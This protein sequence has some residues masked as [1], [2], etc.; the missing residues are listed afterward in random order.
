M[1]HPLQSG[2]FL[3]TITYDQ[4]NGMSACCTN[5]VEDGLQCPSINVH[6][7]RHIESLLA[8]TLTFDLQNLVIVCQNSRKSDDLG[9][10]GFGV[11]EQFAVNL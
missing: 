7:F 6:A 8:M 10:L 11:T 2:F 1:C 4:V 5:L 3:L 9:V